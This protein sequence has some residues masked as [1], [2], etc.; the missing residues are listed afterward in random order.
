[1]KKQKTSQDGLEVWQRY[2]Q[3]ELKKDK[4]W[5]ASV[6]KV[7]AGVMIFVLVFMLADHVQEIYLIWKG[8]RVEAS[9]SERDQ[10]ARLWDDEGKYH[11]IDL[12]DY[13]PVVEPDGHVWLY[14]LEEPD[15]ARPRTPLRIRAFFYGVF[16]GL[17]WIFLWRIRVIYR[18]GRPGTS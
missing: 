11:L 17:L 14:Y 13:W 2:D 1:M 4:D 18:S 15:R 7:L 3:K 12:E 6:W 5:H 10:G 16:S 9:Y 8:H